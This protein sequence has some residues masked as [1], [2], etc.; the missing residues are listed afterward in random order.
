MKYLS[1]SKKLK[2]N[3]LLELSTE[4]LRKCEVIEIPFIIKEIFIYFF[5]SDAPEILITFTSLYGNTVQ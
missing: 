5:N 4:L 1:N 2:N 3:K